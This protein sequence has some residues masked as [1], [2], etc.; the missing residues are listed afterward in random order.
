MQLEQAPWASSCFQRH[1]F[2]EHHVLES[3]HV[4]LFGSIVN[5]ALL[6]ENQTLLYMSNKGADHT[7]QSR[8]LISTFVLLLT[9]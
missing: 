8:S 2:Q 7:A 6:R 3:Y 9:V 4:L 5:V 1:V